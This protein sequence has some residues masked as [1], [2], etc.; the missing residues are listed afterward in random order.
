MF[1][2]QNLIVHTVVNHFTGV[3]SK[4]IK[5]LAILLDQSGLSI[6]QVFNNLIIYQ[7]LE[8]RTDSAFG[9]Q[10]LRDIKTINQISLFVQ[11]L[12][13]KLIPSIFNFFLNPTQ[14]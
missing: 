13:I 1:I 6:L 8:L 9:L 7:F 12:V 5:K 14:V 10:I 3:L 2:I 11:L 4:N